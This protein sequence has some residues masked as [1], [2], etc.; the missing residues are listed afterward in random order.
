MNEEQKILGQR[1][2]L[3][4]SAEAADWLIATYPINSPNW[5]AALSLL[6]QRSWEKPEQWRL[7]RYYL[8]KLP[9]ASAKAYEAFNQIM[10]ISRLAQVL[11]EYIPQSAEDKQLL[12]YH[13]FPLFDARDSREAAE[14]IAALQEEAS[15][16]SSQPTP[17]R[18][19]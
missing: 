1:L 5:G 19:G 14:L 9:Y 8:A 4:E 2:R 16:K 7:A 11:S 15:N 17:Y 3:M 12:L 13:L 6:P 18:G 10:P